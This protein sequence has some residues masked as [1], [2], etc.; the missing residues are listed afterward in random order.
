MGLS[1]L[2]ETELKA[3]KEALKLSMVASTERPTDDTTYLLYGGYE[4]FSVTVTHILNQRAG[5]GWTTYAH[6]GIPLPVY[7]IG[8]GSDIFAGSYDDTD[9]YQKFMSIMNL[10]KK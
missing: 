4:P 1:N 6:T 10:A 9:T 8:A 5:I 3:L 7:A 2:K